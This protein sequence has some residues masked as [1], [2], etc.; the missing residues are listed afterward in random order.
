MG[1]R[2]EQTFCKR[3]NA[4]GQEA[5]EKMLNIANRQSNANQ[6]HERYQFT[7]SKWLSSESIQITYVGEDVE[8]KEPFYTADGNVNWCRHFGKQYR[9]STKS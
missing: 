8:K 6:N 9:C 4:N 1:R 5:D 2:H 7:L 3:A